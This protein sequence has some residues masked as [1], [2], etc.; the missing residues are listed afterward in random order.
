MNKRKWRESWI[1]YVFSIKIQIFFC[2]PFSS[3]GFT[4]LFPSLFSFLFCFVFSLEKYSG[5][6]FP[7]L[8]GSGCTLR[9]YY[10]CS[11]FWLLEELKIYSLYPMEVREKETD[12]KKI[13]FFWISLVLVAITY[14]VGPVYYHHNIVYYVPHSHRH[15]R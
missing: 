12:K 15:I 6:L 5:V 1:F 14:P 3:P 2:L 7:S 9:I 11:M 10:S 8:L 13:R 4:F